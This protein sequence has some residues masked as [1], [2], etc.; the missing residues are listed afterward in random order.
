VQ[1][2][3]RR[4]LVVLILVGV[5]A[6]CWYAAY[7]LLLAFAGVL[8]AIILDAITRWVRK[9]TRL[10]HG[11]AY[12]IVLLVLLGAIVVAI[13]QLAPRLIGQ[14]SQLVEVIPKALTNLRTT[15]SQYGWGQ[16]VVGGAPSSLNL[17]GL[18]GTVTH[19][20]FKVAEAVGG[21]IVIAVVAAYVAGNPEPYRSGLLSLFPEHLRARAAD[22]FSETADALRRWMLGQLVPMVVLGIATGIGL[23]LLG[24]PLVFTLAL[25][26]GLMIFIPYI[27]SFIAFLLTVLVTF[28]QNPGQALYVA[29]FFLAV[30][31]A[32]GYFLTPLVQKKAVY[33]PP[34]LTILAQ[35]LMAVLLGFLGLAL[36]TPMAAAGL[37]LV[38][39]LY[40]HENPNPGT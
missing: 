6:I 15:L 30:H 11:K 1:I 39:M 18:M 21:I 3:A 4:V 34:A 29:A 22:V 23:E 27:G 38:R 5:F 12:A 40:L 35:V 17:L 36:A 10:S 25:F 32:E 33:L 14:V 8:G 28:A 2:F 24:I 31:I 7:V 37:V 16:S 19:I 13:W 26:T 9:R 20:A